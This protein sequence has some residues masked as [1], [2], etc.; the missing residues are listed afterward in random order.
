MSDNRPHGSAVGIPEPPGPPTFADS[1]GAAPH[2]ATST[3]SGGRR[4]GRRW[5]LWLLVL[6]IAATAIIVAKRAPDSSSSAIDRLEVGDCF[7]APESDLFTGS[8]VDVVG[9]DQPHNHEVYAVGTTTTAIDSGVDAENNPEIVRICRTDVAP[10]VLAALARTPGV[11]P[12]VIVNRS[13]PGR[14]VCTANTGERTGSL[15][16]GAA[17]S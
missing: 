9:C 5:L 12:G 11:T 2:R 3:T 1:P 17:A 6:P 16:D 7:Q 15:I 13:K 10:G 8:N 4:H 14:L